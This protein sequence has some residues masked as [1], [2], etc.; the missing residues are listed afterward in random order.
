MTDCD[1]IRREPSQVLAFGGLGVG[2]CWG[3]QG[4]R[5]VQ[6]LQ[7]WGFRGMIGLGFK[8]SRVEVLDVVRLGCAGFRVQ[9]LR[10]PPILQ[11]SIGKYID[12]Y[13][14]PTT[15]MSTGVYPKPVGTRTQAHRKGSYA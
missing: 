7:T 6:G 2:R 11:G 12:P 8:R 13:P 15:L 1:S 9:G 14:C 3:F 4:F 10:G 5:W